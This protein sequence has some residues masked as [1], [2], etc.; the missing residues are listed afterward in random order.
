[1]LTSGFVRD[2]NGYGFYDQVLE[3]GGDD[4]GIVG[5]LRSVVGC[6]ADDRQIGVEI[7]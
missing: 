2:I 7:G 4:G 6:L 3:V 5:R 1:M